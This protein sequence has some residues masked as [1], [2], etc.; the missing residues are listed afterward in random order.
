MHHFLAAAFSLGP[1]LPWDV[2]RVENFLSRSLKQPSKQN[3]SVVFCSF[4]WESDQL[5]PSITGC[6]LHPA[7]QPTQQRAIPKAHIAA[8]KGSRLRANVVIKIIFKGAMHTTKLRQPLRHKG[9]IIESVDVNSWDTW[10][11]SGCAVMGSWGQW[12][13]Y[14]SCPQLATSSA[15]CF[16]HV[17]CCLV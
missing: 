5:S 17:I 1:C 12:S 3:Y 4:R 16:L 6:K 11:W 10:S 8:I 7:A 2:L 13:S 9:T 15:T 14:T